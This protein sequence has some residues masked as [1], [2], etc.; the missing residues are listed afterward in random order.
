MIGAES[1]ISLERPGGWRGEG[2]PGV[3][4]YAL[5]VLASAVFLGP[6]LFLTSVIQDPGSFSGLPGDLFVTLFAMV[7]YVPFFAM[8]YGWPAALVGCLVVHLVCLRVPHQP[9]HVVLA[10]VAGLAAGAIYG[11]GLF[12]GLGS[13][14]WLQ[15]G[16]ATAAGRAVVIPLAQR[17]QS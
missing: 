17:R 6:M 3:L 16:V 9:V 12:D 2:A 5:A 8:L 14:L 1:D 4:G 11:I 7:F 13:W 15:L 10:G